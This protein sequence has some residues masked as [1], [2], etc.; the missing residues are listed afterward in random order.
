MASSKIHKVD[1]ENHTFKDE[2]T[3]TYGLLQH[4]SQHTSVHCGYSGFWENKESFSLTGKLSNS[5]WKLWQKHFKME[6]KDTDKRK[7]LSKLP[8]LSQ[9]QQ[10][11]QNYTKL[12]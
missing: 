10:G 6:K 8:C 3:E 11:E 9:A 1:Y 12:H 4:N 5:A 2:W 7:R